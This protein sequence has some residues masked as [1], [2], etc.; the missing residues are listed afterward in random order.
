[1]LNTLQPSKYIFLRSWTLQGSI[2]GAMQSGELIAKK[3]YDQLCTN[4]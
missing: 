3:I 1:M 2:Q 4:S